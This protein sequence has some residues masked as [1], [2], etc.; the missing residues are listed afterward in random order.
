M[1]ATLKEVTFMPLVNPGP[2]PIIAGNTQTAQVAA[3]E[4]ACKERLCEFKEYVKVKKV[5]LQLIVNAFKDKYLR[6]LSN[7]LTRHSNVPML[8]VF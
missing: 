8:Q 5:V 6:H 3:Q 4:N 1:H 7:C 2:V